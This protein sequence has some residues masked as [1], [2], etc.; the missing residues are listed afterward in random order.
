MWIIISIIIGMCIL[1]TIFQN[2]KRNE[3]TKKYRNPQ[4]VNN[5][6]LKIIWLGETKEQLIDSF[7]KP[8]NIKREIHKEYIKETYYYEEYRR[9]CYRIKIVLKNNKIISWQEK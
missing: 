4:I 7:G 5:I 3:L 9:N 6:M 1:T 8:A 2:I